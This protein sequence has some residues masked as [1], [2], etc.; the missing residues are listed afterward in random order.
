MSKRTKTIKTNFDILQNEEVAEKAAAGTLPDNQAFYNDQVKGLL[1]Q[2]LGA[3]AAGDEDA[4]ATF[5]PRD[6]QLQYME[7]KQGLIYQSFRVLRGLTELGELQPS[8]YWEFVRENTAA[9][10][11]GL[12]DL[13][14]AE[15]KWTQLKGYISL[16][17]E[18]GARIANPGIDFTLVIDQSGTFRLHEASLWDAKEETGFDRTAA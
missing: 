17:R 12:S 3:V 5:F 2:V 13:I 11:F 9:A 18:A 1:D 16:H 14:G 10:T 15:G 8:P 4:Y 6:K 7:G